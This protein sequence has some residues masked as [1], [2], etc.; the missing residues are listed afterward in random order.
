[1]WLGFGSNQGAVIMRIALAALGLFLLSTG[2]LAEP[3]APGSVRAVDGDTIRHEGH[4]VRLIGINAP[5][6]G[7]HAHCLP[8]RAL[9]LKAERRL[10]AIIAGGGLDLTYVACAC[11]LGTEGTKRCNFGR[12]CGVLKAAGRDVAQ[13]L[14]EERLAVPFVCGKTSCPRLPVPWCQAPGE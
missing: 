3:V 11:R 9:G 10:R 12:S 2:A 7:S 13:I 1:M 6:L 5:E 8:E 4:L 14:V